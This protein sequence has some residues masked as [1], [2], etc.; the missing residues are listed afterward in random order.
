MT[1]RQNG[2]NGYN[3]P[4]FILGPELGRGEGG[5]V[6]IALHRPTNK[7]FALKE[8]TIGTQANR[9]QL[10][11]ELQTHMTCGAMQ[12]I[13]QLFD[14]FYDEGR[15]YLVL[16][17]MD[18]GSLE[19]LLVRQTSVRMDEGVLSVIIRKITSAL[20]FLHD[21][22]KMV[23][24]DLKPGNVVLN[25]AGVVKLSDFGVSRVLDNEAK[26][27]SWVGTASYM[28]PERL[29]GS[30]YTHKA[31][32]WS[33]GIMAIECAIGRHPYLREDGRETVFFELMQRVVSDPPPI[34]QEM[35]LS[36]QL[37]DFLQC[38]LTKEETERWGA[39]D[40][41]NHPFMTM[42]A[43]KGE[44]L[45]TQWLAQFERPKIYDDE[46]IEYSM[47]GQMAANEN[48]LLPDVSVTN[49]CDA[50]GIDADRKSVV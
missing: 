6:R 2:V 28:S 15:V 48:L 43:D 5:G 32:I 50:M 10:G 16:E 36:G 17:L 19:A 33:L 12:D 47:D 11:K 1:L 7:S 24:R 27:M 21:E 8:I 46:G 41:L 45:V 3:L 35:G 29:M 49:P 25:C 18:W 22:H 14:V 23:H 13:V 4:D 31:D 39:R 30:Q 40:L 38:C 42:H 37:I 34:P 20:H 9:H 44:E 26:G